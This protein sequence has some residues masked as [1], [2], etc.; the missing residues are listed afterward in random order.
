M[1]RVIG[2]RVARADAWGKV[3]GQARFPADRNRPGRLAGMEAVI[4]GD[5]GAYTS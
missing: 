4:I 2:A 5:A 1:S 3:L